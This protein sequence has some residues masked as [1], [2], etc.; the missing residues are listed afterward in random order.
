MVHNKP[1]EKPP[2]EA[3]PPQSVSEMQQNPLSPKPAEKPDSPLA[4][5]PKPEQ[6]T[7]TEKKISKT[8]EIFTDLLEQIK[9]R[10]EP[11]QQALTSLSFILS[12]TN[13]TILLP[14]VETNLRFL[15]RLISN[16]KTDGMVPTPST[17]N[18]VTP[19]AATTISGTS[20]KGS[21]IF[22]ML[23]SRSEPSLPNIFI[24]G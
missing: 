10:P 7:G 23:R 8:D 16:C 9:D 15:Y 17:N 2:A 3:V 20:S 21:S 5:A 12:L 24:S 22:N 1:F 19:E 14:V 13:S 4:P 6:A 18:P 11:Q